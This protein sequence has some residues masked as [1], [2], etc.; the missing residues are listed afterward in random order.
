MGSAILNTAAEATSVCPSIIER[1][2]R[3]GACDVSD[4]DRFRLLLAAVDA[5]GSSEAGASGELADELDQSPIWWSL[6]AE[7]MRDEG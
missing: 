3:C 4:F 7:I 5:E 1:G 2:P 6:E